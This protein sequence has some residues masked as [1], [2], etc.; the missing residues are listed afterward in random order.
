MAISKEYAPEKV[1]LTKKIY[2]NLLALGES[3]VELEVWYLENSVSNHMMGGGGGLS[4]FY[5]LHGNIM[6]HMRFG[7]GSTVATFGKGSIFFIVKIM[8]NDL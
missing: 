6:V 1:S 4:K 2:I 7:D 8:I 5:E 3:R